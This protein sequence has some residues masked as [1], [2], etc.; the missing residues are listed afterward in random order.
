MVDIKPA[1]GVSGHLLKV[2]Y[3][4]FVFRV[5]AADH[6]FVDYDLQHSD[7]CV[8]V[9]DPDAFLYHEGGQH[10]LDHAPETLGK[11]P[12]STGLQPWEL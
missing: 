10:Y 8:T 6:T 7:L 12:V 4:T 5:Y 2:A 1:T 11:E 3:D 9:A